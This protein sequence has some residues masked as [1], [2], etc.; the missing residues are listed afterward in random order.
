[1]V[2]IIS[3]HR[4]SRSLSPSRMALD[5]LAAA[6][7]SQMALE[8]L[9]ARLSAAI[10]HQMPKASPQFRLVERETLEH[11]A[12]RLSVERQVAK[13]QAWQYLICH[14]LSWKD[15]VLHTSARG[16]PT[17]LRLLLGST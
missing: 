9:A 10:H 15:R 12:A 4:R 11:L 14:R 13:F 3:R 1:M 5:V 2:Y 16:P 7:T 17:L 8:L 6:S